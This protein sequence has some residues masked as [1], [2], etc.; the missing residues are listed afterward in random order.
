MGMNPDTLCPVPSPGQP[1]A[2]YGSPDSNDAVKP[3]HGIP[4]GNATLCFSA[5]STQQHSEAAA[6][7]TTAAQQQQQRSS[8]SSRAT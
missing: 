8:S 1:P 5:S 6:A 4:H 3:R 2:G 7:T